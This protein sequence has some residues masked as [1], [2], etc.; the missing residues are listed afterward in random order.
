MAIESSQ[1][2]AGKQFSEQFKTELHGYCSVCGAINLLLIAMLTLLTALLVGV[3]IPVSP[4]VVSHL[5]K[6]T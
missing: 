6:G 1:E 3:V 2:F 5:H 4:W